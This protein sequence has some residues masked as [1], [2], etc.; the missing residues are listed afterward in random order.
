MTTMMR[1]GWLV[2]RGVDRQAIECG[3]DK[4]RPLELDIP[5]FEEENGISLR[6]ID[7][8]LWLTHFFIVWGVI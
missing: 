6:V 7:A 4:V 2:M 3:G 8:T 5:L 1:G